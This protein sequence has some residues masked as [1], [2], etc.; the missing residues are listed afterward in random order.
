[1][2]ASSTSVMLSTS[3]ELKPADDAAN[4]TIAPTIGLRPTARNAAAPSGMRMTY[5]ASEA[6]EPV[7]PARA[8]TYVSHM[9]ER[10]L[11]TAARIAAPMNPEYSAM[12]TPSMHTRIRPTGAKVTKLSTASVTIFC[13]YSEVR[14]FC[15]S[16]TSPLA[17]SF[18]DIPAF[19]PSH[20]DTMTTPARMTKSQNGLGTAL[21]ARSNP[22]RKPFGLSVAVPADPPPSPPSPR[23]FSVVPVDCAMA[24]PMSFLVG[25]GIGDPRFASGHRGPSGGERGDRGERRSH[26]KVSET[27]SDRVRRTG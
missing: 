16:M 11:D 17:G 27:N 26:S 12:A 4:A 14:R 23:L 18:A 15:T 24:P 19:E 1:M 8:T 13:R 20:D 6:T 21:P 3:E 22:A 10:T 2:P 25:H 5:T 7:T 9:G